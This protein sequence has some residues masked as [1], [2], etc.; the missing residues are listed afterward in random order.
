M[1][2][3][4]EG[5]DNR[6]AQ[7][8]SERD[9]LWNARRSFGKVLMSMR[10]NF[11]AEDLSVPISAIPEMLARIE[12]LAVETGLKIPVVPH[13][14]HRNLHPSIVFDD[15]PRDLVDPP[16]APLFAHP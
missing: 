12:R 9:K 2:V 16:A 10:K 5:I 7:S 6:L 13:A 4:V 8:G 15:A 14:G 3:V 1:V 11:F